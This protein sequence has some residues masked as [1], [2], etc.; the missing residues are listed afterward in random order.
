MKNNFSRALFRDKILENSTKTAKRPNFKIII[1]RQYD[2]L[3]CRIDG[4]ISSWCEEYRIIITVLIRWMMNEEMDDTLSLVVVCRI[5]TSAGAFYFTIHIQQL[6][7]TNHQSI[8]NVSSISTFIVHRIKTVNI[9]R[10]SSHHEE[11]PP[12]IR[13][14]NMSYWRWMMILKLEFG[15]VFS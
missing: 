13:H 15:G 10:Y 1:H 2:I 4:C 6:G 9:I 5:Q 12:S 14:S 11:M 8:I 7:K 3:G